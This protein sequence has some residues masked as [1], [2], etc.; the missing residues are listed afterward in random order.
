MLPAATPVLISAPLETPIQLIFIWAR[1]RTQP[2]PL[3]TMNGWVLRKKAALI[4]GGKAALA[5]R[6]EARTT[7]RLAATV[8]MK[9]RRPIIGTRCLISVTTQLLLFAGPVNGATLDRQQQAVERYPHQADDEDADEDVIR[10][11]EPPGIH[12]HPTDPG[13]S[14]DDLGSDQGPVDKSDGQPRPSK[15]F[16]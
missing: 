4:C 7:A 2:S 5:K 14:S 15:D 3:A 1:S 13:A 12:N 16:G 9:A 11:Q 8:F 6:G 10:A